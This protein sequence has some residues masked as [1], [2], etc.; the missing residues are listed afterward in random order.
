MN[1]PAWS[2][3]ASGLLIA[4]VAILHVFISHFA[5]GGG[6]FLVVEESRARRAQDAGLLDYVRR[7]SRFFVLV[8]LVLGAVTGVG[9]W[10]T[11]ALVH[12]Q[13]TSSLVH[14]FLWGWAI[15][16]ALF[17]VE[18]SAAMVYYYGWDRLSP[19]RHLA[20]GW[21]YFVSAWLSLAV[22]NGILS[23]MLT[24]GDWVITGAFTDGFF[25]P[26]YAPTL[27]IRTLGAG[28]LAGL[29]ALFTASSVQDNGLR[30]RVAALALRRWVIPAALA[31]PIGTAWFFVAAVAGGVPVA[32]ILGARG[33]GVASLVLAPFSGQPDAGYPPARHAAAAAF[34]A[35]V[36]I[37]T[38]GAAVLA[39]PARLATRPMAGALL[40]LGLGAIGGS[41]W[42]REDLR[43]PYVIGRFMFV[44][45]VRL[46]PQP[47]RWL[48]RGM[49]HDPHSIAEL[50][51]IG[52]LA[53][54]SWIPR[55]GP[56]GVEP[57]SAEAGQRL[58]HLA[59]TACHTV[60]GHLAIRPLVAGR[61]AGALE[62]LIA[63]LAEPVDSAGRPA[64][65]S[66]PGLHLRTWRGRQMPP[67]A[68]TADERRG[69]AA[70][71]AQL[72]GASARASSE[73]SAGG[74]PVFEEHCAAC[75]GG[76]G[77]WPMGPRIRGRSEDELFELIARLPQV[78]DLM[79]P[80]GGSDAER[81]ALARH[82][83][84]LRQ[85]D[86]PGEETSR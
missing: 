40:A 27:V 7:H 5:V 18:I 81:R 46:P 15:E 2:I 60:D 75:H 78:N 6:L 70:Y 8:T 55:S 61:I 49:G 68:G 23:F 10:F 48:G 19:R 42:V 51:R 66:D 20:V 86:A 3:P 32:E 11:I 69:L 84:D 47:S 54:S 44:S 80:F 76:G 50:S 17:F 67:F 12:P 82:L 45:G 79:P 26:T 34:L 41:E 57:S 74:L 77:E 43:K 73:G 58:F 71:L 64:S 4:A 72:G 22:I 53:S 85:A 30:V 56:A 59:C 62:G 25:N 39:A 52:L 35:G 28:L 83:A 16:W 29:Y 65:W 24:P 13:A 9:V 38:L 37:V 21:V 14:V 63:R 36:A 33:S 1:Y 31:I